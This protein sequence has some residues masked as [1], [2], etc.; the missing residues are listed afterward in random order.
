MINIKELLQYSSNLNVLYVEDDITFAQDTCE[1]L[2]NFFDCVDL[3][4]NGEDGLKKYLDFFN[5]HKNYYDIVITD[6]IMPKINGL[7]LTKKIYELNESQ[8][9]IVMSAHNE[10]Q[11]LLEFVNIGIEYFIV[12]PFDLEELVEVFY[13]TLNKITSKISIIKLVNNFTWDTKD[14]MLFYNEKNIKL[15]KKESDFIEI[16]IS[17]GN[18]ISTIDNILNTIWENSIIEISTNTLNPIISRLRKKLPEKLIQSVYGIG[19]RIYCH[20]KG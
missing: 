13:N 7:E 12:K 10:S 17:N 1:I 16:L 9:V 11:Y 14:S 5:L 6:I 18:A 4:V 8:P 2:E 19:Y 20:D 3:A 15:T